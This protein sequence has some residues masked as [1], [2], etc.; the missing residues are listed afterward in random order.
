MNMSSDPSQ[1]LFYRSSHYNYIHTKYASKLIYRAG[2]QTN[3]TTVFC[4]SSTRKEFVLTHEKEI[5]GMQL[6]QQL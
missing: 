6:L 5:L 1:K 3:R 2:S 4:I